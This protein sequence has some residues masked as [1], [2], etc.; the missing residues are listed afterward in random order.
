MLMNSN[1]ECYSSTDLKS[2]ILLTLLKKIYIVNAQYI[3]M[4]K[5]QKLFHSRNDDS[6]REPLA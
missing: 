4:K 1:L 5:R 6:V 2:E 3:L